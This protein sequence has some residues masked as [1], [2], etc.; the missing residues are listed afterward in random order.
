MKQALVYTLEG[1]Q[2]ITSTEDWRMEQKQKWEISWEKRL[3]RL[4][5]KQ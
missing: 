4:G 5:N 2:L 3:H 1:I